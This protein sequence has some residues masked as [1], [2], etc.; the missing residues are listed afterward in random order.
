M[1]LYGPRKL[2]DIPIRTVFHYNP[3]IVDKC[4][5]N[6]LVL[7]VVFLIKYMYVIILVCWVKDQIS[8]LN[9]AFLFWTFFASGDN[10]ERIHYK[11]FT[12]YRKNLSGIDMFMKI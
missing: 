8:G 2:V 3:I 10:Q 9:L 6:D 7:I 12:Y 11:F 1:P 4:H 5:G